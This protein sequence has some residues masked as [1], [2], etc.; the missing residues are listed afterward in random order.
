MKRFSQQEALWSGSGHDEA[1]RKQVFLGRGVAPGLTQL[2][3]TEFKPGQSVEAH[4]HPDMWEA[5]W[6][7]EG[8][9]HFQ[10]DGENLALTA[11]EGVCLMPGEIHA[12]S[13]DGPA[14]ARFLILGIE[15]DPESI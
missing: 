14:T 12:L 1:I 9:L 2:C 10:V 4:S 8:E 3:V 15:G 7:L 5:F 6:V 11:G 13:N